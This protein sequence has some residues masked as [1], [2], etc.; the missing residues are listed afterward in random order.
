[1][2]VIQLYCTFEY[3]P[4]DRGMIWAE[5]VRMVGMERL[6]HEQQCRFGQHCEHRPWHSWPQSDKSPLMPCS[7]MVG[8]VRGGH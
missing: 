3:L 4:V 5:M 2:I 1:M 8:V 7:Q 6:P